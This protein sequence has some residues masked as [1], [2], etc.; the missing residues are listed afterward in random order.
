MN[1]ARARCTAILLAAAVASAGL[2][3]VPTEVA[4]A[5][6][7]GRFAVKGAG[8]ASCGRFVDLRA[9]KS[10]SALAFAGWLQ[11]YLT[12]YNQF[13]DDTYDVVSW[14]SAEVLLRA[15]AQYC[16]KNRDKKFYIAVA[17]L[18]NSLKPDRLKTLSERVKAENGDRTVSVYREVLRRVQRALAER[19]FYFGQIDGLYGP[20]TRLGIEAFQRAEKIAVTGL[21]D[22][23]TL[24][25]LLP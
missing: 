19:G 1:R 17:G 8:A 4:A 14:E 21:P 12:A 22:Q 25:R 5:D 20:N 18:A 7:E 23:V 3:L 9:K 11:G 10:P 6:K 24:L 16:E 15:I 2:A 13:S